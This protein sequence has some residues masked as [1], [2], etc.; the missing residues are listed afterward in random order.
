MNILPVS[1]MYMIY[2][3]PFMRSQTSMIYTYVIT[4]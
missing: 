4:T 3:Y 1:I 2:L